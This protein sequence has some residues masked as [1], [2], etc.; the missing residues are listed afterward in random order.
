MRLLQ[1]HYFISSAWKMSLKNLP[2]EIQKLKDVCTRGYANVQALGEEDIATLSDILSMTEISYGRIKTFSVEESQEIVLLILKHNCLVLIKFLLESGLELSDDLLDDVLHLLFIKK[3][4]KKTQNGSGTAKKIESMHATIERERIEREIFNAVVDIVYVTNYTND[5]LEEYLTNKGMPDD[6]SVNFAPIVECEYKSFELLVLSKQM[7]GPVFLSM[8]KNYGNKMRQIV[9]EK[10]IENLAKNINCK[11]YKIVYQAY[12]LLNEKE[13]NSLLKSRR[14]EKSPEYLGF[15][16]SLIHSVDSAAIAY[17]KIQPMLSDFENAVSILMYSSSTG[18]CKML[19]SEDEKMMFFILEVI[20]K[21]AEYKR[22][23]FYRYLHMFQALAGLKTSN[24]IK[25]AVYQICS[26]Y[27]MD[28]DVVIDRSVAC[29]EDAERDVKNRDFYLLGN[30]INFINAYKGRRTFDEQEETM[31]VSSHA[32]YASNETKLVSNEELYALGQKV[33]P[34]D[35]INMSRREESQFDDY[36]ALGLASEDPSTIFKCLKSK[37][38]EN[39]IKISIT[40]LR[41]AMIKDERIVRAVI[42][43]QI[44]FDAP[45]YDL[46]IIN[47]ILSSPAYKFISYVRLFKKFSFY[48]N[49][50][51]LEKISDDF[52]R[53]LE[54]ICDTYDR[55]FGIFIIRNNAFFNDLLKNNKELQPRLLDV[56]IK[57][58]KENL[59]KAE[60]IV[61]KADGKDPSFENDGLFVLYDDEKYLSRSFFEIF[62]TQLLYAF[63][64]NNSAVKKYIL[65]AS[66]CC[67][68]FDLYLKAKIIAGKSVEK[69]VSFMKKNLMPVDEV[70]GYQKIAENTKSSPSASTGLSENIL[71]NFGVKDST[72]FMKRFA[73]ASDLERFVLFFSIDAVDRELE[74]VLKDEVLRAINSGNKVYLKMA[75]LQLFRCNEFDDI[76]K[77]LEQRYED[78]ELLAKLNVHNISRNGR[79]CS[80][81]L[82]EKAP[83]ELQEKAALLAYFKNV[84]DRDYLSECLNRLDVD[85]SENMQFLWR[86]IHNSD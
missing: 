9:K 52:G 37:I 47:L 12:Y 22:T 43:Y 83:Q 28:R 1:N 6:V 85:S 40:H 65:D 19:Q 8:I 76:L 16:K 75:L 35:K 51:V 13:H 23:C 55:D 66:Y 86:E 67:E 32:S 25:G 46:S 62:A 33:S 69:D 58:L 5:E 41:N 45:I 24:R 36:V 80:K 57:I 63:Y 61:A 4:K 34:S 15:V 10:I 31:N 44:D 49:G 78:K 29:L 39:V 48:L 77:I 3:I 17:E 53:A 11:E 64:Y 68:G 71:L 7:L 59:G 14:T 79:Y 18:E 74:Q 50:D 30:V 73:D 21:V 26:I 27:I 20:G 60:F 70:L 38:N 84:W 54:W 56:Y 42:D 82:L 81:S 2:M 72:Y